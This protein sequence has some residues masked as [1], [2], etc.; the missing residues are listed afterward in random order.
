MIFALLLT[1]VYTTVE[2]NVEVV[3]PL[4]IIYEETNG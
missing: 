4:P 3:E 2:L 1:V